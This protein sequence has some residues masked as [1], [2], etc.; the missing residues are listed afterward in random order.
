MTENKTQPTTVKVNDFLSTISHK[1][2][3]EADQLISVMQDISGIVPVMWGPSIIGFGSRHY[4]YDSGRQGDMPLLSFSPRRASITIYFPEGF[5]RYG[6]ELKKLG[7]YKA[8]ISCLYINQLD[9]INVDILVRMLKKSYRIDASPLDKPTSVDEFIARI[10]AAARPQFDTLRSL[11]KS[12]IPQANEVLSY[13]V[14]GYKIDDKRARI[15]ISGWK[16]HIAIYPVP[17]E[18]SLH[19]QLQPYIK[20]KGTLWFSLD[21]PLPKKLI[22]E[23]IEALIK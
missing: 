9:D 16:D 1:R 4:Q 5:D 15:F 22:K 3:L 19:K 12:Q 17:K 23:T 14:V 11:I 20:G 18:A 6:D 2:R 21:E 13:G 7:K 8:S 10:P